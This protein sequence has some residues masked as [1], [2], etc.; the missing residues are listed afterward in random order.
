[1]LGEQPVLVFKD[2]APVGEEAAG[3]NTALDH[4]SSVCLTTGLSL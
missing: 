2:K 3:G 1:M 4:G